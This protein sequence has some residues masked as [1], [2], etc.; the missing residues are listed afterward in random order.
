MRA[1][2]PS[3]L[4]IVSGGL[5]QH[6]DDIYQDFG[7]TS[8]PVFGQVYQLE[9]QGS[10]P[11]CQPGFVGPPLPSCYGDS[12]SSSGASGGQYCEAAQSVQ[13]FCEIAQ[14]LALPMLHYGAG[15]QLTCTVAQGAAYAYQSSYCTK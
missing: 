3:E 8:D 9:G 13:E 4:R 6:Q 14:F 10:D 7:G 11:S 1:L 2:K 15:I 12:S 5:L